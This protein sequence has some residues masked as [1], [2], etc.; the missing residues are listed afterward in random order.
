MKKA[1]KRESGVMKKRVG[2]KNRGGMRDMSAEGFSSSTSP[3]ESPPSSPPS[4]LSRSP[5]SS[6]PNRSPYWG[7]KRDGERE[8]ERER[9]REERG[10]RKRMMSA[11]L[12]VFPLSILG[13][14]RK[15]R[16][17]RG[18]GGEQREGSSGGGVVGLL[19]SC[20]FGDAED[21]ERSFY[22][23]NSGL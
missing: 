10:G 11:D 7:R 5:P 13:H 15:E 2:G 21:C 20:G 4:S 1:K 18:G 8:R 23:P 6:P 16:E 3:F 14:K 12:G 17:G 9:D 22:H 19:K